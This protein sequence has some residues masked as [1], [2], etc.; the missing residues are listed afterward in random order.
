MFNAKQHATEIH[1]H[2]STAQCTVQKHTLSC[3][4]HIVVYRN[5]QSHTHWHRC[6]LPKKHIHMQSSILLSTETHIPFMSVKLFITKHTS[7]YPR[8]FWTLQKHTFTCTKLYYPLQKDIFPCT[9][10]SCTL[11][12]THIHMHS[13]HCTLQK[14]TFTAKQHIAQYRYTHSQAQCLS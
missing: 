4:L 6:T 11:V 10:L 12:D 3:L 8:P 2:T 7:I 14:H 13:A 1:I 5:T 9:L